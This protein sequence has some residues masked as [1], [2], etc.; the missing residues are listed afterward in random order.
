MEP[1]RQGLP[2]IVKLGSLLLGGFLLVCAGL[3]IADGVGDR[4]HVADCRS[5]DRGADV[6]ARL[7]DPY[8]ALPLRA[9]EQA[10]ELRDVPAPLRDDYTVRALVRGRHGAGTGYYL[11][12]GDDAAQ[13]ADYVRGFREGARDEHARLHPITLGGHA[14]TVVDYPGD[15]GVA[16]GGVL[17]CG[18]LIVTAADEA[19]ARR[20]WSL[21]VAPAPPAL[22]APRTTDA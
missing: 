3:A 14:A 10:E 22:G 16:V 17:R 5:H 19:T 18:G 1:P 15:T 8:G 6:F 20:F 11:A 13:A 7:R 12:V 2:L 4:R 9:G 21:L